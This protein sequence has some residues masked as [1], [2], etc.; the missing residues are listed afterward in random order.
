MTQSWKAR[1]RQVGLRRPLPRRPL[2]PPPLR[3]PLTETG[4]LPRSHIAQK[5]L[6]RTL[7]S[8]N[9]RCKVN[10]SL[11]QNCFP[12]PVTL[13]LSWPLLPDT[14]LAITDHAPHRHCQTRAQPRAQHP[15]PSW[16]DPA[17]GRPSGRDGAS[18]AAPSAEAWA[19]SWAVPHTACCLLP[20]PFLLLQQRQT[21]WNLANNWN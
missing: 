12:P 17:L 2:P 10:V 4:M 21:D 13:P 20:T 16:R 14:N 11:P 6:P 8:V 3:L 1:G 9:S 7:T 18:K 5:H 19:R 15:S